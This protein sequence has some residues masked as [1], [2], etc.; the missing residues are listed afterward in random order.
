MHLFFYLNIDTSSQMN[1]YV[2]LHDEYKLCL[3]SI[4]GYC[5]VSDHWMYSLQDNY[6]FFVK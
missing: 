3:P 6:I 4:I 5:W 2:V 1:E